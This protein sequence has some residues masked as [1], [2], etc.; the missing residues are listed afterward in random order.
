MTLPVIF[1]CAGTVLSADERDLFRR[2]DPLG[3]IVF[4]RNCADP[5]Q[6]R[7]LVGDFRAT[8]GRADAPVLIDQ[9][10]G[11]VQRLQ[12]PHWRAAPPP[13]RFGAIATR[14]RARGREGAA[15]NARLIA[16][17]LAD[18]GIDVDCVPCVDLRLPGAHQVI[19]D[20]ALGEDP[21]LV[22]EMGRAV[23][24]AFLAGGVLPVVKHIPGHGRALSD[25]HHELPVVTASAAELE[26]TDF[27]PFRALADMPWAMTAH[28][29]YTAYDDTKPA[30]LSRCVID[31][32]IRGHIGFDGILL[33][34]DL[35]MK[36]LDGDLGDLA[37][38]S[39][40]AGCD[41]A[42]HCNGDLGEMARVVAALTPIAPA[43]RTRLEA[44]RA[45]LGGMPI[46]RQ[47][48]ATRLDEILAA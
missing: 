33:S 31:R 30:T 32:V 8:V 44:G 9:E 14:D 16:A 20:R 23:A 13:A 37:A 39:I 48:A 19:G 41:L 47:V 4:A 17:E 29:V 34:D 25:S 10:G 24:E 27:V 2:A 12:P 28:V 46:D 18:L 3:L 36:A 21:Q 6:I 26:L 1:G 35:N 22:A 5:D 38:A 40:A 11:R 43:T 42:L 15:L 7:A 45:R